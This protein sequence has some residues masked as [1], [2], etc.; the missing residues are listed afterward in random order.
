M[1]IFDLIFRAE[2]RRWR[3]F[4]VPRNRISKTRSSSKIEEVLRRWKG[5]NSSKNPRSS[6]NISHFRRTP[7]FDLRLRRTKNPYHCL[8]FLSR[9]AQGLIFRSIFLHEDRSTF[10]VGKTTR[11]PHRTPPF[12]LAHLCFLRSATEETNHD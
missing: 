2:D 1:T 8:R 5:R 4:F 7:M 10:R 11:R 12:Y 6:K 9:S 3:G